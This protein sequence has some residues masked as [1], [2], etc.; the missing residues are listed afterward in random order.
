MTFSRHQRT[1]SEATTHAFKLGKNH[2]CRAI[3]LGSRTA[4]LRLLHD[5]A[6]GLLCSDLLLRLRRLCTKGCWL[7]VGNGRDRRL[8]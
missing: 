8:I 1:T 2:S 5:I 7:D 3:V 4:Q 6:M